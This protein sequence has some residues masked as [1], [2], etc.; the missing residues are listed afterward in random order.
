MTEIDA[1]LN[2]REKKRRE[3]VGGGIDEQGRKLAFTGWHY[4]CHAKN[5]MEMRSRSLDNFPARLGAEKKPTNH[6]IMRF[7]ARGTCVQTRAIC[8]NGAERRFSRAGVGR[9]EGPQQNAETS[10]DFNF[11]HCPA[12]VG[13]R[14]SNS[15]CRHDRWTLVSS[16]ENP[17]LIPLPLIKAVRP[18]RSAESSILMLFTQVL[19]RSERAFETVPRVATLVPA[20]LQ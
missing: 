11:L 10:F 20:A 16:H 3:I 12:S 15:P 19:R 1:T 8:R 2:G 14:L 4:F 7:A 18:S 13:L 5:R 9:T 17:P 6:W